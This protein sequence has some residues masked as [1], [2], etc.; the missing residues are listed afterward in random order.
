VGENEEA[1]ERCEEDE[2]DVD[3][4]DNASDTGV[5]TETEEWAELA[6][7]NEAESAEYALAVV[8]SEEVEKEE[9]KEEERAIASL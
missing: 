5:V 3:F 2:R 6:F 1:G 8:D 7:C 9:G 4:L